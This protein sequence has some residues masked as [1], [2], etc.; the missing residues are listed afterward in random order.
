M[1]N[2][3]AVWLITII[4]VV[5]GLYSGL[6][7][8]LE[9]IPNITAPVIMVSTVYPGATPDDIAEKVT[10]PIEQ[11]IKNLSGVDV[12]TST[13]SQN[14][15]SIQIQYQY[16]KDMDKAESEIKDAISEVALPDKVQSPKVSKF[17]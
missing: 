3:F 7:M 13:S 2:K 17:S 6:K 8:K 12:V 16:S 9:T 1:K 10:K 4:V 5:A 11:R 15:S 14:V